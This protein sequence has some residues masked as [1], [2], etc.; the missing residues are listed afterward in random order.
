MFGFS[1]ELVRDLFGIML[2]YV[3]FLP[4]SGCRLFGNPKVYYWTEGGDTFERMANIDSLLGKKQT[5]YHK[6]SLEETAVAEM[7]EAKYV[8]LGV[9]LGE[10]G[11]HEKGERA[12]LSYRENMP[13]II[14]RLQEAGKTV[15]VVNSCPSENFNEVDL[16]DL[17]DIN[18]EVQQWAMPT[19][20]QAEGTLESA[21]PP[22]LF[23]ALESGK[24]VPEYQSTAGDTNGVNAVEWVAEKGIES[25]TLSFESRDTIYTIVYRNGNAM[26]RNKTGSTMYR[27]GVAV[28]R[29]S[30]S[31]MG[32]T[33]EQAGDTF[34]VRG[35]NLHQIRFYRA[36]MNEQ[37]VRAIA[38][39]QMLRSSL[40]LYCPLRAGDATN[41]AQ[42]Q[43]K[44]SIVEIK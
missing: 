14:E 34:R 4:I 43:N 15:V 27:N 18:L 3:L 5:T 35:E 26:Y 41:Y 30:V 24:A 33:I 28:N 12:L 19:I 39:G 25:Y 16:S 11:L 40:E 29:D 21:I 13:R 6:N 37:E 2:G 23:E 31:D 17:R 32:T 8:V 44:I 20:N 42:T 22:T 1:K 10:E 36:A 7:G 9:G 38:T